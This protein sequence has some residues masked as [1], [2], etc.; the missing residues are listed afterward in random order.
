MT[1]VVL[2]PASRNSLCP[3]GSGSRYKECHGALGVPAPA[4]DPETDRRS[5]VLAAALAAQRAGDL[6]AAEAS[7]R[8]VLSEVPEHFD[9]LHMLGVVMLQENRLD[10]AEMLI[11][12]AVVLRPGIVAAQENLAI[13]R[14]TRV[15]LAS[16]DSICRAVMPRLARLCLDPAPMVLAGVGARDPVHVVFGGARSDVLLAQR[17]AAAATARGADVE[18]GNGGESGPPGWLPIDEAR[19]AALA[20]ATVIVVGLDAPL[21]EWP[22]SASPRSMTLVATRDAP[23]LLL[24]R[25]REASGQGRRCVALAT[26]D[27]AVAEAALLPMR[28]FASLEDT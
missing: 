16:E 1:G 8:A 25:V 19:L 23:C 7:Y 12:R 4:V 17:I 15:A 2:P 26:P 28:H 20:D 21:G 11:A 9:A 10:E 6:V 3:C 24:E 13:V 18:K 5:A 14:Q 22:L 27:A